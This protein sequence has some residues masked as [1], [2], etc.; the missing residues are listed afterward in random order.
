VVGGLTLQEWLWK[1]ATIRSEL[2]STLLG[3]CR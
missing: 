3:N 2:P 1:I